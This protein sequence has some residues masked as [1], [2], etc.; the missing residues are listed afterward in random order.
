MVREAVEEEQEDFLI[1]I[2][3]VRLGFVNVAIS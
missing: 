3:V 2:I 1:Q